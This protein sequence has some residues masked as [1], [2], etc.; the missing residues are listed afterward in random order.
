MKVQF[1]LTTSS[2]DLDR[3]RDRADLE[4]MMEGF[5]GVELMWMGEDTRKI[6]PPERVIG[7]HMACKPY[8]L[9][10]WNGDLDAC[11]DELGSDEMIRAVYGGDTR[12][13]LTAY[14]RAELARAMEYGAE[15]VVF[16]ASDSGIEETL[17][18]RYRHMDAEVVD[19]VC[20]LMNE[21]FDGVTDGPALLLENLWESG[22]TMTD[23]EITARLLD[24]IAYPNKGLMLDTGHIMHTNLALCTQKQALEYIH[25]MLD[26]HGPLCRSIRG[27][28]LNQ[29][30]NSAYI[31]RLIRHPPEIPADYAARSALLFE[32]VFQV[33]QHK[34]FICRGVR[35]LVDRLKPEY[36]TYEF[37]SSS[38]EQHQ[39]M[40]IRQRAAL[41]RE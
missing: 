31:R 32:Y 11:R 24:G 23:P 37:I 12:D 38:R 33:D 20:V 19:G 7:L 26:R 2:C 15:Y 27:I 41:A 4:S 16:H 17:R 5:D 8:W 40:L 34:P 1:N 9:D 36:L 6:V 21:V 25:T 29:S 22:L 39:R 18:R 14:Y 35:S 3:Y 30:L 10:F 28:H 13:A